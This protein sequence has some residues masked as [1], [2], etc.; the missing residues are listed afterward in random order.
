MKLLILSDSHGRLDTA[1][2]AIL[3]EKPHEVIHLGD[4]VRDAEILRR[5]FPQ[6]PV[7][8]VPGNCDYGISLPETQLLEREGKRILLTHGHM[9]GVK[10]TYIR[11]IYAALEQE[12]D[13]LLFGH[14]HRAECFQEKGVWV[15]NPGAAG[16]GRYGIITLEQG[17]IACQLYEPERK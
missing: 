8:N 1:R 3:S 5:E 12:A 6:I 7:S 2:Q 15:M 4:Y 16:T 9:Y 17:E 10:T 13:I 14:T 11:A